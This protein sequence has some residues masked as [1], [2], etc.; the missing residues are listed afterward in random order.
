MTAA[1]ILRT[2]TTTLARLSLC[3]EVVAVVCLCLVSGNL[4]AQAAPTNI[5]FQHFA[6]EQGLSQESIYAIHQDQQGF[7]WFAT[8]D[9]LNRYDGYTFKVF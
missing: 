4:L 2:I 1:M 3:R 5:R 9:G 6:L 7:M 8:E